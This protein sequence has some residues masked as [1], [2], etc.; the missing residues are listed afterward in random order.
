MRTY[1]GIEVP[2]GWK[3]LVEEVSNGVYQV[4]L[5]DGDGRLAGCTGADFKE[6]LETCIRYALEIDEQVKHE[7]QANHN[8]KR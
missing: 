7:K 1:C 5:R 4:E 8:A 2:L 6:V 3:A